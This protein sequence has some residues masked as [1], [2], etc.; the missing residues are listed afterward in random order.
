M[1]C[2]Q[3]QVARYK[4]GSPASYKA[5][6]ITFPPHDFAHG[7]Q[8]LGF[9]FQ[10]SKTFTHIPSAVCSLSLIQQPSQRLSILLLDRHAHPSS[11][12]AQTVSLSLP[13]C[14]SPQVLKPFAIPERVSS[15]QAGHAS[16]L[17]SRGAPSQAATLLCFQPLTNTQ[18]CFPRPCHSAHSLVPKPDPRVSQPAAAPWSNPHSVCNIRLVIRGAPAP[19]L[20]RTARSSYSLEC[21]T[22][23]C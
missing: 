14:T 19:K 8:F 13:L 10:R 4:L 7:S 6:T 9:G 2:I 18:H 11:R 3:L 16:Q 20:C 22:D 15:S 12:A 21:S 1:D 5:P 17:Y 23:P